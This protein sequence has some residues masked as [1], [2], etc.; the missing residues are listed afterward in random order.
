M[1]G[2]GPASTTSEGPGAI[3]HDTPAN[4]WAKHGVSSH[5][6]HNTSNEAC[7]KRAL[8]RAYNRA[9]KDPTGC[10]WYRG[11]RMHHS[12]L[13]RGQ[14]NPR[15]PRPDKPE[16][17]SKSARRL[18]VVTWNTGGLSNTRYNEIIE[19]LTQE[20][21]RG[22]PVDV[23]FL[24][25]TCW[26][27]DLEDV[28]TPPAV[29]T[30]E[31]LSYQVVHS[32]GQEKTGVMCLIRTGVVPTSGIRYMSSLAGRLL[33]VRLMFEAALD[34]LGV[35]QHPWKPGKASLEGHK[36]TALM[37]QRQKVWRL[38][39]QSM[40]SHCASQTRVSY[41]GCAGTRCL[42]AGGGPATDTATRP[43]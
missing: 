15:R 21:Q 4:R 37:K 22:H 20:A 29:T 23:M 6:A 2:L 9:A 28:A 14:A 27:Q 12:Q 3:I 7:R 38:V 1:R 8:R 36:V 18:R 35:Y 34:L 10:T 31:S 40:A 41:S 42:W 11:R 19:W 17:E 30:P 32:A 39:E 5:K 25:E 24:Q 13:G 33:H 26:K 16:P 43:G